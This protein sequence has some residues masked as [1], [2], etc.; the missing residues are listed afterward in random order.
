M[1]QLGIWVEHGTWR[2]GS[3]IGW[4]ALLLN[5]TQTH[6]HTLTL[7]ASHDTANTH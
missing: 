3:L 5:Y 2:G 6:A 7:T 4:W 1:G